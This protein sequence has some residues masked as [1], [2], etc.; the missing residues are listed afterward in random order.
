MA[1]APGRVPSSTSTGSQ[2][3]TG[4]SVIAKFLRGAGSFRVSLHNDTAAGGRW[5]SV[6]RV[7]FCVCRGLRLEDAGFTHPKVLGHVGAEYG[8]AELE[9]GFLC[10]VETPSNGL[11][12]PFQSYVRA[13]RWGTAIDDIF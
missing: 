1:R 5:G 11:A 9:E 8:R 2:E 12:V 4:L 10:S 13:L 6:A 3:I 7:A